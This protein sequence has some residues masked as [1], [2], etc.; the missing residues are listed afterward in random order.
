M[1]KLQSMIKDQNVIKNTEASDNQ[2]VNDSTV[3]PVDT[4]GKEILWNI[5]L[6]YFLHLSKADRQVMINQGPEG[7]QEQRLHLFPLCFTLLK[8]VMPSKFIN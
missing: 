1:Y 4:F 2:I 7:D 5:F 3:D 8:P 6:Q